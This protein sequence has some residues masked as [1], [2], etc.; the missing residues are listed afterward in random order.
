[1]NETEDQKIMIDAYDFELMLEN[2]EIATDYIRDICCVLSIIENSKN[3]S[4]EQLRSALRVVNAMSEGW[5]DKMQLTL[6]QLNDAKK[7]GEVN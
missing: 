2:I 6:I 5:A 3:A 7:L 4:I 1:M